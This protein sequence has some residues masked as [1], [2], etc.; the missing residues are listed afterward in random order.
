MNL[1]HLS[2]ALREFSHE[3]FHLV[4]VLTYVE[5]FRLSRVLPDELPVAVAYGLG[6]CEYPRSEKPMSS[7]MTTMMFGLAGSAPCKT[8]DRAW[9]SPS[10][11]SHSKLSRRAKSGGV[12]MYF[13]GYFLGFTLK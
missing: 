9:Q 1:F 12:D 10:R 7:A 6:P 11:P 5:Q 2:N 8:E 13:E 3:V 4:S